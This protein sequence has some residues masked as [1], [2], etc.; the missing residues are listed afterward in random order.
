MCTFLLPVIIFGV[1]MGILR[2]PV[3]VPVV[4]LE[5]YAK[6]LHRLETVTFVLSKHAKKVGMPPLLYPNC[7]EERRNKFSLIISNGKQSSTVY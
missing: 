1:G 5:T 2:I 7:F 6:S 4:V 3:C